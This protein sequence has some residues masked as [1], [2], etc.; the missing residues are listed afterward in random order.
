M[1]VNKMPKMKTVI[2]GKSLKN[3]DLGHQKLTRLWGLPIMASEQFPPSHML[4][5]KF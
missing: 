3:A 1:K 5:K 2:L 4:W